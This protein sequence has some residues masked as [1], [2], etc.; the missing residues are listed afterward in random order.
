[1]KLSIYPV[2]A[3]TPFAPTPAVQLQA[4]EAAAHLMVTLPRVMDA[5]RLAMR[6]QLDGPL[7]VPQFRGFEL[8]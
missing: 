6:S 7:S 1:M 3:A 8:H 4:P 5:I 2:P